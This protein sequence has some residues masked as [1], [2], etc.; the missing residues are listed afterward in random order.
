M[1]PSPLPH[2]PLP[3]LTSPSLPPYLPTS[4][5]TSP[6]SL[7]TRY[8]NTISGSK[9]VVILLDISGSMFELSS[10]LARL[11]AT[12]LIFTLSGNDF[13]YVLGVNDQPSPFG[14]CFTNRTIASPENKA[15]MNH[16]LQTTRLHKGIANFDLGLE[17]GLENLK[18]WRTHTVNNSVCIWC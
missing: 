15:A 11:A 18:V 17:L 4:L 12:E 9:H 13:F 14:G 3:S 16:L 5:P 2:L 10:S 8:V 1:T 7:S 6:P